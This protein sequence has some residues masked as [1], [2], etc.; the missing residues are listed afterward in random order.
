MPVSISPISLNAFLENNK[1]VPVN[2][3]AVAGLPKEAAIGIFYVVN[4]SGISI[5][6]CIS[7]L[8]GGALPDDVVSASP[9]GIDLSTDS[10]ITLYAHFGYYLANQEKYVLAGLE[11]IAAVMYL[12]GYFTYDEVYIYPEASTNN[13]LLRKYDNTA[14][15]IGTNSTDKIRTVSVWSLLPYY[16]VGTEPQAFIWDTTPSQGF[17]IRPANIDDSQVTWLTTRGQIFHKYDRNGNVKISGLNTNTASGRYIILWG[18]IIAPMMWRDVDDVLYEGLSHIPANTEY[19]MALPDNA[20]GIMLELQTARDYNI[21]GYNSPP[22]STEGQLEEYVTV[23]HTIDNDYEPRTVEVEFEYVSE[24]DLLLAYFLKYDTFKIDIPEQEDPLVNP[25]DIYYTPDNFS[26][27]HIHQNIDT[28]SYSYS[29]IDDLKLFYSGG[30]SNSDPSLSIGGSKS[31]VELV[32]SLNSLFSDGDY[33]QAYLG[34]DTFRCLYLQNNNISEAATNIAIWID[35]DK[36]FH[37]EL[38]LG[39]GVLDTVESVLAN[40][41]VPPEHIVFGLYV[42]SG[43]PLQIR[44][45]PASSYIAIWFRRTMI[46]EADFS[47]LVSASLNITVLDT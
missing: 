21:G 16:P 3:S 1:I 2:L 8:W 40:D 31:S 41:S 14:D 4:T 37:S 32:S 6:A 29:S 30:A 42:D 10:K 7:D 39:V 36:R 45:L 12:V 17:C 11:N 46:K 34:A 18:Y 27:L 23:C 19:S 43:K 44:S 5:Y 20:S 28:A 24:R 9:F 26:S 33:I 47:G 38:Y 22:F 25:P 13:Q 35:N 15:T